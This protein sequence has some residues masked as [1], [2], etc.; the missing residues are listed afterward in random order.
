MMVAILGDLMETN[1]AFQVFTF[2]TFGSAFLAFISFTI[3]QKSNEGFLAGTQSADD[4][5]QVVCVTKRITRLLMSIGTVGLSV[6]ALAWLVDAGLAFT[7][8]LG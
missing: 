1:R 8:V 2:A 6:W 3:L 5:T 4:D 7:M